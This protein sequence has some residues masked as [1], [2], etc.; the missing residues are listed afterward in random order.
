M[1]PYG[2][3]LE[4]RLGFLGLPDLLQLRECREVERFLRTSKLLPALMETAAVLFPIGLSKPAAP[5][6]ELRGSAE[7]LR[8]VESA[9]TR[10]Q[11]N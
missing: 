8:E 4:F 3:C 10:A 7:C 9:E 6:K 2:C 11:P 5:P 1:A